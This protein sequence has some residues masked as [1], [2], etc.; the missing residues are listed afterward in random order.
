AHQSWFSVGDDE[1]AADAWSQKRADLLIVGFD[2][3]ARRITMDIVEVM[4]RSGSLQ[5]AERVYLSDQMRDESDNTETTL[6]RHFDLEFYS[7][8]RADA[9]F[10]AKELTT[11]LAFYLRRAV[12]YALMG[13]DEARIALDFIQTLDSGY[14][15]D[16]NKLGVVF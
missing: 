1:V 2:P 7:G 5:D 11:L 3:P 8:G 12:R 14:T 16:F 10:R 9:A 15:L 4:M 13:S 6:R